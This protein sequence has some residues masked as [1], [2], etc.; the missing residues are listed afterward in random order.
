[1]NSIYTIGY[2]GFSIEQFISILNRYEIKCVID[3]RS[4]PI[5]NHYIEYNKEILEKTLAKSDILYRNYAVQFG[6][7]QENQRYFTDGYLDF[8]KFVKSDM[9]LDGV[10]KINAGINQNYSFVL[11][12]AE[13]DPITC[14]RC[15]MIGRTFYEDG[16]KVNNIL[17]NGSIE[18]QSQSEQRLLNYYFPNRNQISLFDDGLNEKEMIAISYQ[19]RNKEIG[20]R[21]SEKESAYLYG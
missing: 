16:Y 9:F 17:S 2:S 18:L 14:H 20:Y 11:M 15:I 21:L 7:R 13:K 1:M 10:K 12:C 19:L 3:V 6:A 4:N 5:S 8:T